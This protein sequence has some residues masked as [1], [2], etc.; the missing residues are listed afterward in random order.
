M[1]EFML[2]RVKLALTMIKRKRTEDAPEVGTLLLTILIPPDRNDRAY[3][4]K[5]ILLHSQATRPAYVQLAGCTKV[6]L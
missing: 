3:G 2:G 6:W 5:L 4:A 1:C